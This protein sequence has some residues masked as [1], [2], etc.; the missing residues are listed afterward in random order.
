MHRLLGPVQAGLSGILPLG[1]DM[2]TMFV[3]NYA[4]QLNH[5]NPLTR[6]SA[7]WGLMCALWRF[8][9]DMPCV[10]RGLADC[11][12]HPT[13]HDRFLRYTWLMDIRVWAVLESHHVE[14]PRHPLGVAGTVSEADDA[15]ACPGGQLPGLGQH[16]QSGAALTFPWAGDSPPVAQTRAMGPGANPWGRRPARYPGRSGFCAGRLW[17]PNHT[18][19]G[20]LVVADPET[21]WSQTYSIPIPVHVD[22]SY[23]AESYDAWE[24]PRAR[25]AHHVVWGTRGQQWSFH[26]SKGYIDAVQ[27]RNPGSSP[28]SDDLIRACRGLLAGGFGVPQHLYSHRVGTF[29]DSLLDAADDVAKR[30]AAKAQPGVGWVQGL[31]APRVCFTHNTIQVHNLDRLVQTAARRLWSLHTEAPEQAVRKS[32]SVYHAVTERGLIRWG[33]HLR[34]MARRREGLGHAGDTRPCPACQRE[35]GTPHWVSTCPW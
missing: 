33:A 28:L 20:G 23:Q 34:T 32:L 17:Y 24:V 18:T 35:V 10:H 4:H 9:P 6:A 27:S 5:P 19:G 16:P 21:G 13:D 29:L 15:H 22:G 8:S 26:D 2:L 1:P 3:L 11:E 30:Q 25:G 7:R 14:V 31:Q 12:C